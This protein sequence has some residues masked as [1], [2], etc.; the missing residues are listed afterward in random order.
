MRTVNSAFWLALQQDAVEICEL[1]TLT[2][3]EQ[4]FRWT[5]SNATI[6]SSG[7]PYDPFPGASGKGSEEDTSLGIG[8]I[9]FSVVDSGTLA[10]KVPGNGLD[11]APVTVR[12]VLTHSVDLGTLWVFRGKLGDLTFDRQNIGGQARNLFNG[13]AAKFPYYSYQD[14][15][16][17]RFGSNG[18]GFNTSSITFTG[19]LNASSSTPLVLVARSGSIV[20]SYSLNGLSKGRITIVSG[21]NSGQVRTIRANTG[22]VFALSHS[23]PYSVESGGASFQIYPGCRKSL[24]T[25]CL[26]KYNNTQRFLGFPW[27]PKQQYAF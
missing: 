19:S 12:R 17:W 16:V 27:I 13:V 9:D 6:I 20:Q 26:S 5:S 7:Q 21:V 2:L 11:N 22:D 15:C 1:I 10:T 4:T 23:L 24:I 8:T 14:T 25:D 18:C 3:P